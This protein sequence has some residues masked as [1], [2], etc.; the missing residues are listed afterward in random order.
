MPYRLKPTDADIPCA[1]R[2]IAAEQVA[3]ALRALEDEAL[4]LDGRI[5]AARK[6]VK[7]IRALIRLVR[8]GFAASGDELLQLRHAAA[9][10]TDMRDSS[11]L[12]ALLDALS[13]DAGLSGTDIEALRRPFQARLDDAREPA[14]LAGAVAG[15]RQ[16]MQGIGGRIP[17]WDISGDGFTF[18]RGGIERTWSKALR[19]KKEAIAD[20]DP[21]LLHTL[22]KRVKDHWYQTRLLGP[23]W[24]ELMIPRMQAADALGE[25]LGSIHDLDALVALLPRR[26]P[27]AKRITGV[28]LTSRETLMHRAVPLAHRLIAG[29]PKDLS[30][31]WHR[32]WKVWRAQNAESGR[33]TSGQALVDQR[34]RLL[35]PVERHKPA[36][37]RPL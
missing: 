5:H 17:Q 36:K 27:S 21:D 9:A 25:M 10:V 29:R 14:R 7:K 11:V 24:P 23:I 8:P 2:R 35:H 16:A 12:C 32:W 15:F 18:V 33:E 20:P 31:Q 28:T 3:V 37:A 22:R 19:A 1:I 6:A 30:G 34:G 26:S 4:P 13:R